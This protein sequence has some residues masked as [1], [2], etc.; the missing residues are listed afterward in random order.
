MKKIILILSVF[1]FFLCSCVPIQMQEENN[2][3]VFEIVVNTSEIESINTEQ[4]VKTLTEEEYKELCTELYYDDIFFGTENLTGQYVKLN[5]FICEEYYYEDGTNEKYNAESHFYKCGVARKDEDIYVGKFIDM[6]FAYDYGYT[7]S[8]F[9]PGQKIIVYADVVY[10][11]R[12]YYSGY[13]SVQIV[14]RYIEL[15]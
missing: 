2:E 11:G 8:D 9:E 4:Y 7:V 15:K 13:N 12:D 6:L 3:E 10:W 5:L 1:L 14:P